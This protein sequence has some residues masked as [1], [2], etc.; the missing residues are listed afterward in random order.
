VKG[1][2]QDLELR[3]YSTLTNLEV[4]AGLNRIR[5]T[6]STCANHYELIKF[7]LFGNL[8]RANKVALEHGTYLILK[9]PRALFEE[10]FDFSL[11]RPALKNPRR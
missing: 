6:P 2:F 3:I 5:L 7:K 11:G 8:H 10:T 4:K 9:Y 1:L